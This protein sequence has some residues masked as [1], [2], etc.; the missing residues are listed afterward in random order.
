M[1]DWPHSPLHRLDARG[2]YMVTAGTYR[3]EPF[4]GSSERLTFLQEQLFV[5]CAEHSTA[6]QAWAIFPNHYHLIARL[7]RPAD[8]RVLVQHFHSVTARELNR[9]DGAPGRKIWFQYWDSQIFYQKSYF[10]RLRYVHENAV[11]HGIVARA[12][13]YAWCSAGW[14]ER[15]AIPGFRKTVLA[16]PCESLQVPDEF[17]VSAEQIKSE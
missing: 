9:L 3:K 8:L 16:F 11:R 12:A 14:F 1:P 4:F 5:L 15:K 2:T 17:P 6:L 10:A 13:N 7:E